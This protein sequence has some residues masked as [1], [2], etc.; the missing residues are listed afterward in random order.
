LTSLSRGP[1]SIVF[2]VVTLNTVVIIILS[3]FI[4]RE[5]L[6]KK[7]FAGIVCSLLAILLL[8]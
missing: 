2:P 3:V 4:Y 8:K 7:S 6:T 1:A 5:R